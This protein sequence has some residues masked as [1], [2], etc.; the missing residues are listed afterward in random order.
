M[1]ALVIENQV[2]RLR[3]PADYVGLP[4]YLRLW[5]IQG[6]HTQLGLSIYRGGIHR[7]T[8]CMDPYQ[9]TRT[10]H[11]IP[12]NVDSRVYANLAVSTYMAK[13]RELGS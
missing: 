12:G 7:I 8:Y 3:K 4:G 11:S 2:S 9:H 5:N 1:I 10:F 6:G 13:I